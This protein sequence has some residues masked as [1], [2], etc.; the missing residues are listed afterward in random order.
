[1]YILLS[2]YIPLAIHAEAGLPSEVSVESPLIPSAGSD[3]YRFGRSLSIINGCLLIGATGDFT[4]GFNAGAAYAYTLEGSLW[5]YAAKIV[6]ADASRDDLFGF[7]TALHDNTAAISAVDDDANGISDVGSVY[8]YTIAG[9]GSQWSQEGKLLASDATGRD[10]FGI[11]LSLEMNTLV[12][13]ANGDDDRGSNSGSAYV[14]YRSANQWTQSV[15]L[16]PSDG[17]T[18]DKFGFSLDIMGRSIVV[19]AYGD[20]VS[21][22]SVYLYNFN[23]FWTQTSKL[24]PADAMDA[25]LF[26]FAVHITGT[27]VFA[28]SIYDDDNGS[29]SGAV[30]VFSSHQGLWSEYAKLTPDDASTELQ[31]GFSLATGNDSGSLV[32][33][34]ISSDSSTNP[35]AVYVFSNSSGNY[36]QQTKITAADG[37]SEDSFG[38]A[39]GIY[40][41]R[42]VIGAPG[43]DD[44]GIDSG[45]TYGLHLTYSPTSTPTL[46][47][48]PSAVPS[49]TPSFHPSTSKPS[50]Q[51]SVSPP[52][53]YP[54]AS[55][56]SYRPS[57]RPTLPIGNGK[58]S[59]PTGSG[60]SVL[61]ISVVVILFIGSVIVF[62]RHRQYLRSMI[63]HSLQ[64]RKSSVVHAVTSESPPEV[65]ASIY[66]ESEGVRAPQTESEI[67]VAVQLMPLRGDTLVVSATAVEGSFG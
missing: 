31:F 61:L 45:S 50:V 16:L 28:G 27:T 11:S 15:K 12:V 3:G 56:P 30:Y 18:N 8:V 13:G 38:N 41:S 19:G 58:T 10:A 26:G 47:L 9:G 17:S 24:T 5:T 32:I 40:E 35:G 48:L 67:P 64:R 23:S 6:P 36:E 65:E 43:N 57:L 54:S 7:S 46:S 51:P 53:F 4:N 66:C 59:S 2:L 62:W 55:T 39:V 42:I 22:G 37:R 52:T 1:M 60:L 14:F 21:A 49:Y 44:S 33:G 34:A 20:D 63:P 29:K 25:D